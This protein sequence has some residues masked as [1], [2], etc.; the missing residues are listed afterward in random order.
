MRALCACALFLGACASVG[1]DPVVVPTPDAAHVIWLDHPAEHFTSALPLGNGSMGAL[2]FGGVDRERIVLNEDS[3]WSGSVQDPNRADAH[4]YLPQIQKLLLE[5]KNLEAERLLSE[6]FTCAGAGSGQGNGA[7][8]PYGCYQVLG[9]LRLDFG[10]ALPELSQWTRDSSA[11]GL[12]VAPHESETFRCTFGASAELLGRALSLDFSPIDDAGEIRLNGEILGR[13]EDWSR[14]YSFD[15]RG[16]LLEGPNELV[17]KVTNVGGE[18][19]MAREV[20]LRVEAQDYRNEL[21][22]RNGIVRTTFMRNGTRSMRECFVSKPHGLFVEHLHC[23]K[24][25]GL[26]FE[27]TLDR[28]EGASVQLELPELQPTLVL[29][30]KLPGMDYAICAQIDTRGGKYVFDGKHLSIEG[31]NE[32]VIRLASATSPRGEAVSL[33]CAKLTRALA[34]SYVELREAS[35]AD[36]RALYD[37]CALQLGDRH[38]R[39]AEVEALPTDQRLERLAAGGGDPQLAAL[40]FNYGRYLLMNSSRPG[41]RPANLQGLWAE[42][43]QTPWNGDYHLDINVQM[44]YWPAEVANLADCHEPLFDLIDSLRKPGAATAKA[45]YDAPGWVAHVITNVWGFTAPGED[46]GWGSTISGG[47]WLADHLWEHYD[48]GRDKAFLARVYPAMRESAQFYRAILI[49]ERKHHW[50]VTA[51]SNSPEHGFVMADGRVAHTC[52]GPTIDQELVR[53]LFGDVIEASRILDVDADFRADLEDARARLA[54]VQVG[55]TGD[56]QEWLE[57]YADSEPHHR[58]VSHL[59]ALYPGEEIADDPRLREA[60]RKTLELRGDDGTG[61]SLAWKIAFWA[62]LGDGEHALE[63]WKRLM[64]PVV[65]HGIVMGHGGTYP[66]LFCAHPPFQIDGNFGACAGIAEM[67]VQSHGGVV[68]LLPALPKE[69]SEGSVRGLR[70]RGGFEVDLEWSGGRLSQARVRASVAGPLALE[71][72]GRR[73]ERAMKRGEVFSFRR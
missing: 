8:V 72:D 60:A 13:T 36:H 56:V 10:A 26:S 70:A 23:D 54:P 35:V 68:R 71:I 50:L 12:E 49:E 34:L 11:S 31:A 14:A 39:D 48:F 43:T 47:A 3:L 65:E 5:G 16:K 45:Y 29:H 41:T 57:D 24:P 32:A 53:E 52:M 40:D 4:E 33:A 28:P 17:V 66:N 21:D 6:H 46:A 44:N 67:L 2:V 58:H 51:P 62:R 37:R 64:R 7:N 42:E 18:G 25:G 61:W 27:L 15:V 69:W 20:A 22:L 1:P 9:N 63:L 55:A 19:H 30:G 38:T 59:Y 73:I